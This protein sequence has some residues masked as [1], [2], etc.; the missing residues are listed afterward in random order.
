[1]KPRVVIPLSHHEED[2]LRLIAHGTCPAKHL[3]L[4]DVDQLCGLGLVD[5][6]DGNVTLTGF[7]EVRLAQLAELRFQSLIRT[8]RQRP[9]AH[10]AA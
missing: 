6:H 5:H 3:R 8:A 7:G 2:T 10:Q 4:D 1:M 9:L